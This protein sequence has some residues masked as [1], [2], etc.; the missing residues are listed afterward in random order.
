NLVD[1]VEGEAVVERASEFPEWTRV[2]QSEG[3]Y[4]STRRGFFK[5]TVATVK[6]TTLTAARVT[7]ANE[8]GMQE[9]EPEIGVRLRVGSGG[10]LPKIDVER[11][12]RLLDALDS[13][14]VPV[15]GARVDS[16]LFGSIDI[17][18]DVCNACGMCA[19]FCPTMA[20]VRDEAKQAGDP[21]QYLEFQASDC[22][23]CGLCVDVC[24][25]RCITL[26]GDVSL[27]EI[28]DFEPRV[29]DMSGVNHPKKS[30]FGAF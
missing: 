18:K 29:F 8:L 5:D 6:E 1:A 7:V 19:V 3:L 13:I 20:L 11:R 14:G 17:N 23:Q 24:W 2:E 10:P 27:D 28:F 25:K 16:R 15:Q 26:T 30:P 22:I 9:K 21:V 12:G 4:G